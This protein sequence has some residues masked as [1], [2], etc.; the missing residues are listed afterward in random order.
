MQ[1]EAASAA[2][3]LGALTTSWKIRGRLWLLLDRFNADSVAQAPGA[4]TCQS[5]PLRDAIFK[6]QPQ[7]SPLLLALDEDKTAHWELLDWSVQSALTEVAQLPYRPSVCAWLS[8]DAKPEVL[9]VALEKKLRVRLEVEQTSYLRYFDPRVMPRLAQIVGPTAFAEFLSP[10]RL[11]QQLDRDGELLSFDPPLA[12]KPVPFTAWRPDAAQRAAL[13]RVEDISR[14]ANQ[15][16]RLGRS[17]KHAHNEHLDALLVAAEQLGLLKSED[18]I[19]YAVHAQ[20]K[21][22][23]FTAHP[24]L[25]AWCE[26]A[27]TAGIA[28]DDVVESEFADA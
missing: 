4:E 28:F 6:E 14:T 17:L 21:G 25:P 10:V 22:K 24:K 9:N 18:R 15:L 16:A 19:A 12:A 27:L 7:R 26:T 20:C 5:L 3:L 11:W 1:A 23:A 8:T 2:N 13:L